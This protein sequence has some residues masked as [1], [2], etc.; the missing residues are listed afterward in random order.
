MGTERIKDNSTPTQNNIKPY[1]SALLT[2]I[3]KVQY[4]LSELKQKKKKRKIA[5]HT[6][7]ARKKFEDTKQMEITSK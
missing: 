5:K 3:P 7:N 4:V 6:K 1:T 2:L